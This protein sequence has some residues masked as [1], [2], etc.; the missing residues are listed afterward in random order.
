MNKWILLGLLFCPTALLAQ[1]ASRIIALSPH[2]VEM[3]Y[4]IGAGESIVATTDHADYPE[5]AQFIE[6]VGGYYGIQ[7]E[8]VVV[9]NPDL[10][11]V[12]GSGN[13]Q[14]D[15]DRLKSL[16]F[17]LFNS[18]PNSLEAVADELQQLGALTGHELKAKQVAFDYLT[19]LQQVR[20]A[21]ASKAPI[22]VFYQL[23]STPLMTVA[24]GSWIQQIID[25]C[26]GDNVFNDAENAYPQVSL[27]AV[28]LKQPMVILQS[29]DEGNIKGIDWSTWQ[30]IPAVKQQHI[31]QLDADLLHRAA[32]RAILG[33]EALCQA[34]DKAR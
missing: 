2:A 8:K 7:I 10:I 22:K 18:D 4:A 27:E 30:E 6:R 5:E 31:Y 1:P 34:L 15:I 19:S 24:Q 23:W 26:H 29:Q 21:N 32:P 3:L 17:P 9:L 16:G 11:V 14:E 25:V 20:Q 13:K 28:L 12:W 33:V